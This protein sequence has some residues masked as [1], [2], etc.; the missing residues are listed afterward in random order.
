MQ[1]ISAIPRICKIPI[2][3]GVTHPINIPEINFSKS[4]R[5]NESVFDHINAFMFMMTS[6]IRDMESSTPPEEV[7]HMIHEK[8]PDRQKFLEGW[9][10]IMKDDKFIDQFNECLSSLGIKTLLPTKQKFIDSPAFSSPLQA[11][12]LQLAD[13]CAFSFRRYLT[14]GKYGDLLLYQMTQQEQLGDEWRSGAFSTTFN[15]KV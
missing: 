9:F 4:G 8:I 7:A 11:P 10:E 5:F 2:H 15:W 1:L 3:I 12:I 6:A 14:D 13:A